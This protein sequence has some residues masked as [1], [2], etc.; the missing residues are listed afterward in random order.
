MKGI[1]INLVIPG[2]PRRGATN[3]SRF[4]SDSQ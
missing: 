1:S 4:S 3:D 2:S